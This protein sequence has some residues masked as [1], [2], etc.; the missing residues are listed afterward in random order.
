MHSISQIQSPLLSHALNVAMARED[1]IRIPSPT[2][3]AVVYREVAF[4]DSKTHAS[5]FTFT[6]KY[7]AVVFVGCA[8]HFGTR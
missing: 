3:F 1:L 7:F 4:H 2:Q 5:L 8:I 6:S